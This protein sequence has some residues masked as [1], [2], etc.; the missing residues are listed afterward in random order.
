MY[1]LWLLSKATYI[2]KPQLISP[3][4]ISASTLS[5]M[6]HLNVTVELVGVH[7]QTVVNEK[8]FK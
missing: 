8:E 2:S 5:A 7:L 6:I 1:F 4:R 3:S